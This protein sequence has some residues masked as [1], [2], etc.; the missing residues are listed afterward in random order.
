MLCLKRRDRRRS[1]GRPYTDTQ[2][3]TPDTAKGSPTGHRASPRPYQPVAGSPLARCQTVSIFVNDPPVTNM[4]GPR[5]E[6]NPLII[7]GTYQN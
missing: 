4:I 2:G 6:W 7:E 3:E 1:H 5:S